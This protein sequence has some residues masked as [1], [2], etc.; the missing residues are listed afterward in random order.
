MD[1]VIKVDNFNAMIGGLIAAITGIGALIAALGSLGLS[2][3]FKWLRDAAAARA[4]AK[5]TS[6]NE[7]KK[8]HEQLELLLTKQDEKRAGEQA[9]ADEN[10]TLR[11]ENEA[12]KNKVKRLETSNARLTDAIPARAAVKKDKL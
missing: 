6:C 12:L 4:D 7:H 3:V 2:R 9:L 1:G 10:K 5:K 8:T 11:E